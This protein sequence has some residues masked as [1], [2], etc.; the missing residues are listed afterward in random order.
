MHYIP[1]S[2]PVQLHKDSSKEEIRLFRKQAK[3]LYKKGKDLGLVNLNELQGKF[4]AIKDG[5]VPQDGFHNINEMK[6]TM[7]RIVFQVAL[8]NEKG[9]P[10]DP[11]FNDYAFFMWGEGT[12]QTCRVYCNNLY[13]ILLLLMTC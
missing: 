6:K 1:S 8:D 10:L 9:K 7:E 12:L 4:N 11:K 5:D 2:K 3:A 13:L